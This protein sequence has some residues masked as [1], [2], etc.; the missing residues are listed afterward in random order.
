MPCEEP[1]FLKIMLYILSFLNLVRIF[2]PIL[3]IILSSI[4]IAKHLFVEEQ[5]FPKI[6]KTVL[7]RFIAAIVVFFVP[8]IASIVFNMLPISDSS[9]LACI[10]NATTEKILEFQAIEDAEKED[11]KNTPTP[12]NPSDPEPTEPTNPDPVE[13]EP[14]EPTPSPGNTDLGE[15]LTVGSFNL[16]KGSYPAA[17][18]TNIA[19]LFKNNEIDIIGIQEA[20]KDSG[21]YVSSITT[22]SG[23]AAYYHKNSPPGIAIISKTAIISKAYQN[24][25]KCYEARMILKT[26]INFKGRTISFYNVH[27]SYQS[28][29]H[30][31]Q[32]KDVY[33][34]IK[35]DP[36]PIIL[37]GDF[38]VGKSCH[39]ITDNL[40]SDFD[41]V[42][43]D[44]VSSGIKCTDS[45]IMRKNRGIHSTG[46]KTIETKGKYSDHNFVIASF[47]TN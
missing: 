23:M 5:D 12:T 9:Y 33:D 15:T 24:L 34:K 38:N 40:G 30:S 47:A 27:I 8:A 39:E 6:K 35:N 28:R 41:L 13:P 3:L 7:H 18:P 17:T 45:I 43:Y 2:V 29:C 16:H 31:L 11:E 32:I 19:N 37:V 44:T 1:N 10:K 46:K 25:D 42:A 21:S 4:D 20:K 14:T 36:N 22:K 26:V